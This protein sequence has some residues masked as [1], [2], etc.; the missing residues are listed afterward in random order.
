M[1]VGTAPLVIPRD[2]LGEFVL[3]IP[4]S[5]G[6]TGPNFLQYGAASTSRHI[7]G[8]TKHRAMSAIWLF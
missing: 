3:P 5:F 2:T 8:S 7:K 1:N 6:S 4:T